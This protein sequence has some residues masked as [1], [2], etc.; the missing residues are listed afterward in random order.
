MRRVWNGLA[1]FAA[2]LGLAGCG[3]RE[4]LKPP[5]PPE[6]YAVP[7]NDDPRF[8]GPP[9]YPAGTLNRDTIHKSS[10]VDTPGAFHAGGGGRAGGGTAGGAY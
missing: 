8:A 6:V 10:D 3:G 2:L 1:V 4:Y 5:T 9:Q 7:P